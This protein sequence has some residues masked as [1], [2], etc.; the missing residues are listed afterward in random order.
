MIANL[1]TDEGDRADEEPGIEVHPDAYQQPAWDELPADQ[2]AALLRGL[3]D[4]VSYDGA[5]GQVTMRF[6]PDGLR[7]RL[8]PVT[9]RHFC[10]HVRAGS[11]SRSP[12]WG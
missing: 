4:E 8:R 10:T 6:R 2:K 3:I 9:K 12:C 5:A 7:A 1:A 11:G